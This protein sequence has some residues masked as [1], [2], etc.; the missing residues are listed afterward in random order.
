MIKE[1]LDYTIFDGLMLVPPLFERIDQSPEV[2]EAISQNHVIIFWAG[3]AISEAAG[4]AI[5][6]RVK[7]FT[8][9]GSTE[10]GM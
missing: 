8:T 7:I 4:I 1:R 6:S 3:G 2:L 5:S 9:C 10:I